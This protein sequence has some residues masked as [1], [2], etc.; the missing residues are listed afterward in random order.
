M[1]P[2]N[3][4]LD[5][6]LCHDLKVLLRQSFNSLSQ[7]S[8]AACSSLSTCSMC[9]FLDSVATKFPWSRQY[10]FLQPIHYVATESNIVSS[11]A[12]DLSLVL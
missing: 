4:G 8:I 6:I 10:S 7:V 9:S 2:Q 12:I 3:S 11:V 5:C 1:D